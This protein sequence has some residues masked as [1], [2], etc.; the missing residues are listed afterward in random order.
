MRVVTR[1]SV[2]RVVLT[3]Q[4]D[5]RVERLAS[6]WGQPVKTRHEHYSRRLVLAVGEPMQTD[7]LSTTP[8]VAIIPEVD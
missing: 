1:N 3:T 8:V 7:E 5:F 6:T 4:S 2:Y